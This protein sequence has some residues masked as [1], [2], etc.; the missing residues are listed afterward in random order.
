VA[1]NPKK[2]DESLSTGIPGPDRFEKTS[3]SAF[4]QLHRPET[5]EQ[6]REKIVQRYHRPLVAYQMCKGTKKYDAE[7]MVQS[8]FAHAFE[9]WLFEK[10]AGSE[11]KGLFRNWLLTCYKRYVRDQQNKRADEFNRNMVND[12]ASQEEGP[13]RFE[14]LDLR[15][16]EGAY[17]REWARELL[18]YAAEK[19]ENDTLE[20][21]HYGLFAAK[22]ASDKSATWKEIAQRIGRLELGKDQL[23][24]IYDTMKK[25]AE[26]ILRDL[27]SAELEDGRKPAQDE[28]VRLILHLCQ[29]GPLDSNP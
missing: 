23:E 24:H 4:E 5:K 26:K 19:L 14:A 15:S 11:C 29:S 13:R 7:D 9:K 8:F 12:A 21:W 28:E 25:R 18:R 20:K 3:W 16:P 22:N 17:D 1:L 10:V 6:A 27:L 2:P